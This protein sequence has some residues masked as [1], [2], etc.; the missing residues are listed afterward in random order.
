MAHPPPTLADSARKQKRTIFH[1]ALNKESSE[2]SPSEAS[3]IYNAMRA[4]SG[5]EDIV[6]KSNGTLKSSMAANMA[7]F[8]SPTSEH[9]HSSKPGIENRS[10]RPWWHTYLLSDSHIPSPKED[11]PREMMLLSEE[12]PKVDY[13]NKRRQRKA[14]S[15]NDADARLRTPKWLGSLASPASPI[16]PAYPPP[17][18]SPTPP[19]LPSFGTEEA[20]LYSARFPVQSMPVDGQSHQRNHAPEGNRAESYGETFRRFFG[21]SSSASRPNRQAC[22]IVRAADGTAVQG[23]FPHRQSA[24]GVSAGNR[25]DNHPFHRRTLPMAQCGGVDADSGA[26][27]QIRPLDVGHHPNMK[28]QSSVHLG[29]N[30]LFLV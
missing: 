21:I 20:V 29:M 17:V 12:S 7:M 24:H 14:A 25:L 6:L 9:E 5:L 22:T 16:L 23:R 13:V 3:S 1:T 18:R 11:E 8:V 2:S 4:S 19:G 28:R 15:L 27:A 10:K 30:L 26:A